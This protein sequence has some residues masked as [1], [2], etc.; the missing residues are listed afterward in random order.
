[1]RILF[2]T[3]YVPSPIRVRPFQFLRE[4]SRRHD[5]VALTLHAGERERDDLA[6]LARICPTVGVHLSRARA[7]SNCLRALPSQQPL[8]GVYARS[9]Q[10]SELVRATLSAP[11]AER[12]ALPVELRQP[13]DLVHVEHLRAAYLGAAIPAST[14]AVVDAVDCISLLL[15]RT[16]QH[17]HRLRQ[18]LLA[19]FELG[20]TRRF[21]AAALE[22]FDRVLVTSPVDGAALREL[23]PRLAVNEI[24]NGVG[25]EVGAG[26]PPEPDS[27]AFVGKMS[28]HANVTAARHFAQAIFPLVR[29]RRP[30]A[31]FYIVG[32]DPPAEIRALASQPGV[33][34]TGHVPDVQPYVARARVAV[35]P[36]VVK[37]GVQNKILEAMAASRPVVTTSAGAE[38]LDVRAGRDLLVADAPTDFAAEVLRLLED[39]GL[40]ERVGTAGRRFVEER[41]SWGAAADEVER[42]YAQAIA[43]HRAGA[44]GRAR[45]RLVP[46][47]LVGSGARSG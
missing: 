5:V 20:R 28:Y 38:G 14:P 34:V 33:V 36:M 29:A 37:V 45:L 6:A 16:R 23:N 24:P 46:E 39:D 25:L 13:F 19:G 10:M 3:P 35:A 22:R 32:S 2:V 21:E 18:R 40:A 17:S 42:A 44:A 41:H 15:D 47:P 27:M 4:L 8:Q 7:L 1:V 31:T 9:P 43:R 12:D 11:P 26:A 30:G